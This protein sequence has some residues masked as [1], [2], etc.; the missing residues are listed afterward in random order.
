MPDIKKLL[1]NGVQFYPD[2]DFNIVQ[3]MRVLAYGFNQVEDSTTVT[4]PEWASVI[5]DYDG[6]ILAGEKVDGTIYIAP[7]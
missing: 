4:N 3:V 7:I 5:T 1:E 6:R 2:N